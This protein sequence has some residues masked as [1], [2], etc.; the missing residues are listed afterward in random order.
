M[1][2]HVDMNEVNSHL[3]EIME[4]YTEETYIHRLKKLFS[5]LKA[6]RQS[7][8]YKAAMIEMQRLSAPAA[9][10][11]LPVFAVGI[12]MIMSGGVSVED[13]IIETQVLEA[14][15]IKDLD[16]IEELKPPEEQMEDV[17]I[18]IPVNSPDVQVQTD[19]SLG[20]NAGGY[21]SNANNLYGA[22]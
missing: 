1:S 22:G 9:A 8:E 3:D 13:R 10:I 20:G 6:P 17:N 7:K 16:K 15:E 11:V 14:E 2:S 5:G 21:N 18:D 19:T 4:M 12:L